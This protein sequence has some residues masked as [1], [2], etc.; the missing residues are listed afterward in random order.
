M[1]ECFG[2]E[3][4]SESFEVVPIDEF[5]LKE[6]R[7]GYFG[8]FKRVIVPY[9][10]ITYKSLDGLKIGV[11]SHEE[12]YCKIVPCNPLL[13]F[14]GLLRFDK[15]QKEFAP[16]KEIRYADE[17]AREFCEKHKDVFKDRYP[18]IVY[19]EGVE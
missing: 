11:E 13:S 14:L 19:I 9:D 3:M 1:N 15:N 8:I 12:S 6:S 16:I 17:A 18:K 7:K 4:K 5:D 2:A 10:V